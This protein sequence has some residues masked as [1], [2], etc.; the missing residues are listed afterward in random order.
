MKWSMT[1]VAIVV[2][3]VWSVSVAAQSGATM[4]KGDTM[5]M[6]DTTYSGCIEAGSSDGSFSLTHLSG[7]DHVSKGKMKPAA[8]KNDGMAKNTMGEDHM[9]HDAMTPATFNLASLSIDLRKHLGHKVSVTGSLAHDKMDAMD[10]DMMSKPTATFT[11]TSLKML[12]AS[13]S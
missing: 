3:A 13:C 9:S 10:K 12:A 4:A 2:A 6:K 11:V 5:Q 7:D 1:G 8:V